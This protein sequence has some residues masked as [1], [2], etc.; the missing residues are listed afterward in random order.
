MKD[1]TLARYAALL[2]LVLPVRGIMQGQQ[3]TNT[4]CTTSGN[5]TNCTSNTTDYSAQQQQM[6]QAGQQIGNALGVGIGSAIRAH[7]QKKAAKKFCESHPGWT[8]GTMYCPTDE[9]K[10]LQAANAFMARHKDY[11]REPSN[12]KTL[13]AYL[14]THRLD[15]REE[16]SYERAYTDLKKSGELDLYTR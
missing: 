3:T 12:S 2:A 16:K 11:I 9:D 1:C 6:Y 14:D 15:P 5:Y 10:G 13:V 4:N 7:S 8:I